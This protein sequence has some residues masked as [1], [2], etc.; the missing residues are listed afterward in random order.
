MK[1]TLQ[2]TLIACAGMALANDHIADPAPWNYLPGHTATQVQQRIADGWRP[3][4]IQLRADNKFDVTYVR[5]EGK[6]KLPVSFVHNMTEVQFT[7]YLGTSRRPVDIEVRFTLGGNYISAICADNTGAN[8][9]RTRWIAAAAEANVRSLATNENLHP[10]DLEKVYFSTPLYSAV[11]TENRREDNGWIWLPNAT[12]GD[13]NGMVSGQSMRV[14]DVQPLEG[15]RFNAIVLPHNGRK[16]WFLNASIDWLENAAG[17]TGSRVEVARWIEVNGVKRFSGT[18][19]NNVNAVTTRV[20]DLLRSQTDGDIGLYCK[21]VGGPEI[22]NLQAG[23]PFY[24]SS[25]IKI[26]V[27]VHAVR[28]TAIGQFPN[29]NINVQGVQTSLHTAMAR[30]L[31]NSDNDDTNGLINYYNRSAIE[32]TAHNVIG[33]SNE[34]HLNQL[35]GG[36]QPW[37]KNPPNVGT[38]YDFGRVYTRLLDNVDTTAAQTSYLYTRML[39]DTNSGNVVAVLQSICTT[40]GAAVGLTPAQINTYVSKIKYRYKAGNNGVTMTS[41]AG[42]I[43]IPYRFLFWE[44]TK[45]YVFGSFTNYN[46]FNPGPSPT[47]IALEC[48]REELR[49]NMKTYVN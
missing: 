27:G 16:G 18:L 24:P 46:T 1:T 19:V 15:N 31:Q 11:L 26:L 8:Y 25:T 17:N 48:L 13:V 2:F 44:L 45:R 10:I 47:T 20:G 3:V 12:S 29:I 6:H 38:L 43:E 14:Q 30:M 7:S 32:T 49:S 42:S 35:L 22:A 21:Q 39:N 36:S 33:I 41:S 23:R 9:R 4:S 34:T 28:T 40:E 37:T 5:N